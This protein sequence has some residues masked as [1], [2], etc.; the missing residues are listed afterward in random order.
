MVCS[1]SDICDI[2]S[3]LCKP[4]GI[5]VLQDFQDITKDDCKHLCKQNQNCTFATFTKFREEPKCY[6]MTSCHSKV[7]SIQ[8]IRKYIYWNIVDDIKDPRLWV[9]EIV[10]VLLQ[11][12]HFGK[13]KILPENYLSKISRVKGSLGMRKR[14]KSIQAV[15]SNFNHLHSNVKYAII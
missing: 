1:L 5:G 4:V 7:I 14:N 9:N 10:P 11:T 2:K 15:D 3:H 6:L 8:Q 13:S 12:M